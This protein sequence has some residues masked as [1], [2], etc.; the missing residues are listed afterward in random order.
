MFGSVLQL[1]Q[2]YSSDCTVRAAPNSLREGTSSICLLS[3][4]PRT[5]LNVMISPRAH[6]C[7]LRML[8][9]QFTTSQYE[10]AQSDRQPAVVGISLPRRAVYQ[11]YSMWIAHQRVRQTADTLA[12]RLQ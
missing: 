12:T 4:R 1:P 6:G 2:V 10:A 5:W 11:S 3:C 9:P 8:L 7:C